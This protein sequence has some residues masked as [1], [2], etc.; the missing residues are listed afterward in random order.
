MG[1]ASCSSQHRILF[2]FLSKGHSNHITDTKEFTQIVAITTKIP[3]EMYRKHKLD[4]V[5]L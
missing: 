5:T 1:M 3:S 2:S 4:C